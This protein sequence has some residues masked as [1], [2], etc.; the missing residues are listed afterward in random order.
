MNSVRIEPLRSVPGRAGRGTEAEDDGPV[1]FDG[2]AIGE[3]D[4]GEA[5]QHAACP[6]KLIEG[7]LAAE[8]VA[9]QLVEEAA[10]H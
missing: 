6:G 7:E 5:E 1:R 8:V 2:L 3:G 10:L 9:L 4:A